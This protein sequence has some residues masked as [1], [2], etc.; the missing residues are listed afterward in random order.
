MTLERL[1]IRNKCLT[2]NQQNGCL[3]VREEIG[4]LGHEQMLCV[5]GD[6]RILADAFDE[7]VSA[8]VF[9]HYVRC[10]DINILRDEHNTFQS[11]SITG[12]E[13]NFIHTDVDEETTFDLL[14]G[15]HTAKITAGVYGSLDQPVFQFGDDQNTIS[16]TSPSTKRVK[17]ED[18]WVEVTFITFA[19]AVFTI[20]R[21]VKL[22]FPEG[23]I[24]GIDD[25]AGEIVF[26]SAE[27]QSSA[28]T[29]ITKIDE[30]VGELV[31]E[32]SYPAPASAFHVL[33]DE[34][35]GE[36]VFKDFS[37]TSL[38]PSQLSC[39]DIKDIPPPTPSVTPTQTPTLTP[40]QTSTQTPTPTQTPTHTPTQTQTQTQ[41]PSHTPTSTLTPTPT[42]TFVGTPTPTPSVT[43]THTPTPSITPTHT[44]TPSITP[45]HTPTPSF[46]PTSTPPENWD[47][48]VECPPLSAD[49]DDPRFF[50]WDVYVECSDPSAELIDEWNV[51]EECIPPME[52]EYSYR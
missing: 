34:M 35:I 10:R 6:R 13:F 51:Y 1:D 29:L 39:C 49:A 5:S 15:E 19:T 24:A 28:V 3:L 21:V 9:D 12:L 16:F 42:Q 50:G 20:N 36:L 31:F 27:I 43:P 40:T 25:V 18:R 46:T 47:I 45:T 32:D 22:L 23:T 2:I 17:I 26:E 44:P 8:D 11:Q 4:E 48:Y 41:T 30:L 33:L 52:F 37:L 7:Y 14:T 38:P